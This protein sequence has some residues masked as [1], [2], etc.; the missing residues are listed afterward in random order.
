M[1][2]SLSPFIP[3]CFLLFVKPSPC[4]VRKVS[5]QSVGAIAVEQDVC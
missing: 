3:S 2:D 4:K 5:L 1:G